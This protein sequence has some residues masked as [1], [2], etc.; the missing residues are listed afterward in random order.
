MRPSFL[1]AAFTH[2]YFTLQLL[3]AR[4]A[5]VWKVGDTRVFGEA[6]SRIP[7]HEGIQLIISVFCT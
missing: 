3:F 5:C 4:Y 7:R 1:K 6:D 2:S